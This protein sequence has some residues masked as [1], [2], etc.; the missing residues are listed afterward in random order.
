MAEVADHGRAKVMFGTNWPMI[1][2]ERAL[3]GI[4]ELGLDPDACSRF[5]GAN[6]RA[7]FRL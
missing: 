2:P 7:V 6:A 4:D 1:A 3:D 5:L